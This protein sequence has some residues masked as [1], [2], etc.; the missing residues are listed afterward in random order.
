M[1]LLMEGEGS[2]LCEPSLKVRLSQDVCGFKELLLGGHIAANLGEGEG[3]KLSEPS[4]RLG[5]F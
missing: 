4:Q 2:K 1:E 5:F 3:S